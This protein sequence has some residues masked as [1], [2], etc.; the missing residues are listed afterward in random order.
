MKKEFS[1]HWNSSKQPRKQRKFR[2]NAPLHIKGRFLNVHL[3]K[4]LRQKY[5][6]RSIRVRKG[7]TVKVLRG[8][9]KKTTG[10]VERIDTKKSKLYIS[11]VEL[12]KREGSKVAIPI[13]PSNV[14]ITELTLNDKRRVEKLKLKGA[15]K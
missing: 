4:E 14:I 13:E 6:R 10:N 11:K 8:Q 2:Y 7:D 5:K 12:T 3:S 15:Q 9:F 1:T